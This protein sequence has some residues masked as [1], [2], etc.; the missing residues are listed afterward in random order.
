V[1]IYQRFATLPLA[2]SQKRAL[3]AV[4]LELLEGGPDR[5]VLQGLGGQFRV[6]P[7]EHVAQAR[8]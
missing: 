3:D 7:G 1:S 2:K 4:G 8:G 6:E 5:G